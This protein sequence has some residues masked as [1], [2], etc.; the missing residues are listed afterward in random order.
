[1]PLTQPKLNDLLAL[2]RQRFPDWNSFDHPGFVE[3]EVA[4][5]QATIAKARDLLSRSELERL[6]A[7]GQFDEFIARLEKIGQDNNLLWL[8]APRTGDLG[9]LYQDSL[10]RPS[11]CEMVVDLLYGVGSSDERLAHYVEYVDTHRLPNRWAFPTYFLFMCHPDTDMF[12]KPDTIKWFLEFVDGPRFSYG[13]AVPGLY[14]QIKEIAFALRDALAEYGPRDMVDIQG[15]IWVGYSVFRH[16]VMPTLALPLS[17]IF[18]DWDEAEWAFEFLRETFDRLGIDGPDDPRFALTLR[19][20]GRTL[21]LNM[22]NWLVQDFYAPNLHQAGWRVALDLIHDQLVIPGMSQNLGTFAKSNI[23]CYGLTLD[24]A[25]PLQGSVREVYEQTMAQIAARFRG[26]KACVWR[27][28]NQ[29]AIAEAVFDL[30]KRNQLFSGNEPVLVSD[31]EMSENDEWQIEFEMEDDSVKTPLQESL[32]RLLVSAQMQSAIQWFNS[33]P[34]ESAKDRMIRGQAYKRIRELVTPQKL[35]ALSVDDFDQHILKAGGVVYSDGTP[36]AK[37]FVPDISAS[38]L[39]M[40]FQESKIHTIGNCTWGFGAATIRAAFAKAGIKEDPVIQEKLQFALRELQNN[41]ISVQERIDRIRFHPVHGLW[42]NLATG[43]L[44]AL[45]PDQWIV[46]NGKSARALK[47]LGLETTFKLTVE[48]YVIFTSFAKRV[49]S[50]YGLHNLAE[51]DAFFSRYVDLPDEKRRRISESSDEKGQVTI[52]NLPYPLVQCAHDTGLDEATLARWV[53]AIHRKGQAILYGPPGTG[54]TYLAERLA[55]HLVG[56]GDGFVDLVQFHPAYAYEDFVQ[57]IRPQARDDGG[58]SYP[59]VPGRFLEFCRQAARCSGVCVLI[60]DEIN[61]ANLS[62]VLG[63]LMYLLEYRDKAIPLAA[64]GTFAIPANV[65]LV[66]T[67][68]TAD[69]SIALVDHALRRRFAFIALTPNYDV[70]RHYHH[71][72][73]LNVEGLIGVLKRLN[74]E[75][76]DPHY[77]VGITF[78]LDDHLADTLEDIWQMEIEPYL[79]EYFFDQPGK[80]QAFGW[81]KIAGEVL[82]K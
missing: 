43:I 5:K 42:P 47:S 73:G 41:A 7:E 11:F 16:P 1:M 26:W 29:P 74:A 50:M 56:G 8:R 10:D 76:G 9:V 59:V 22:G 77:Y 20:S 68:N 54:K 79:E 55:Q 62:R 32:D 57:G 61:R 81:S 53:R 28:S 78:F 21:R 2:L 64:G 34:E 37:N 27:K 44:M 18:T 52:S 49:Q 23:S 75:I 72:T 46:M 6:I 31:V 13:A 48:N 70:L 3:E 63:E 51:V 25:R 4:Y 33:L 19:D 38:E 24:T 39:Q 69:R 71:P 14:R 12:V 35:T 80:A 40:M 82:P 30:D 17:K 67:M 65:R 60:V 45:E 15:L 36:V 66:G 58:L